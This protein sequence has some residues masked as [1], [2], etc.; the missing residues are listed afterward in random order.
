VLSKLSDCSA[1][2][3]IP[4]LAILLSGTHFVAGQ[5]LNTANRP[6]EIAPFAETTLLT[7]DWGTTKNLG[8]TVGID[9]SRFVRSILQPSLE[10]RMTSANGA[11]VN[12]HT[13]LGGLKLQGTIHR[14]HPYATLLGG[15]GN[16][17]YNHP[18]NNYLGDNSL[19]YS[20]G[21]GADLDVTSRLLIRLDFTHQ[22]WNI[23]PE[24]Y[25]PV[26]LG[27][28]FAYRLPIHVVAVR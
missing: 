6:A 19:V 22:N 18:V 11:N 8:Y 9:Y 7:P 25:T 1:W 26:T 10:V 20:L 14:V 27:M 24:T 16:I 12:E 17:H 3:A 23:D 15:K 2:K 13:Y 21:A 5:A 4:I 28:G